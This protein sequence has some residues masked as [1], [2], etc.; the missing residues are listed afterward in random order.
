[1]ALKYVAS[2][3]SG[4]ANGSSPS[5][6]YLLGTFLATAAPG[7]SAEMANGTYT[8]VN[9]M[10]APPSGITGSSGSPITIY[11]KNDGQVFINGEGAR[12]PLNL[13]PG[14]N[15][16][17][18][19]GINFYNGVNTNPTAQIKSND[20]IVR[21]CGVWDSASDWN[22][23]I[24]TITGS[25]EFDSTQ[26]C[27]NLI[28]DCF[29]FGNGRKGLE[30]FNT[31][32]PNTLR[33]FYSRWENSV[34]TGP[35]RCVQTNYH[36]KG[37][38][39]DNA[40]F[41]VYERLPATYTLQNNGSNFTTGSCTGGD[42]GATCVY[43]GTGVN[44]SLINEGSGFIGE[45]EYIAPDDGA[46]VN[47][48]TT[49]CGVLFFHLAAEPIAQLG[50]TASSIIEM[51]R[52]GNQALKDVFVYIA[53]GTT[54][55]HRGDITSLR[56]FVMSAIANDGAG[57]VASQCT[58]TGLT[59]IVPNPTASSFSSKWTVIDSVGGSV[60]GGLTKRLGG[61]TLAALG[62]GSLYDGASG[63]LKGAS[64]KYRYVNGALTS[65]LLWPWP[66]SARIK[67]ATTL[68]AADGHVPAHPIEDL[69]ATIQATFG[70]Y[71][72]V[73][74][75]VGA[76][77]PVSIDTATALILPTSAQRGFGGLL[78]CVVTLQGKPARWTTNGTTP[79][80]SVGM[81]LN[82][83]KTITLQGD[84]S[85]SAFRIIGTVAGAKITYQYF[86]DDNRS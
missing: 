83:T 27:R 57:H 4:A 20:N 65:D 6:A 15:W 63:P 35:K 7:D 51:K 58:A 28:E 67:A 2:S 85:I 77:T 45:N 21:R 8:G 46:N 47:G 19:D 86:R 22:T 18:I 16:F 40:I 32:G 48:D 26:A 70:A 37:L 69:D 61:T 36:S 52:F 44:P 33:R 10:L 84:A 9:S 43:P 79:T 54:D 50:G 11:A 73:S 5:D 31:A 75:G 62:T 23:A 74:P 3:T 39:I 72:T 56:G 24:F 60:V 14:N 71:P 29:V 76:T 17:V 66:M 80:A 78:S 68:A 38:L 49:M 55:A 30:H 25:T 12:R 34:N 53:P 59:E 64:I 13:Q 1:M 41:R 82:P 81:L 42:A